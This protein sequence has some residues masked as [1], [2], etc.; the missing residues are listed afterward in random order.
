MTCFIKIG[1]HWKKRFGAIVLT[2]CS[3]SASGVAQAQSLSAIEHRLHRLEEAVRGVQG[4]H[5][6]SVRPTAAAS[7]ASVDALLQ[8]DSRLVALERALSVFVSAQEQD[9]RTLTASLAQVQALKGDFE[10]RLNAMEQQAAT[11]STISNVPPTAPVPSPELPPTADDRFRQAMSY[12]DAQ[13]WLKSELAFD[14]FVASWPS[15][16]RVPEARFQLGRAF[17]GQGKHAQAAQ[18]FLGLYETAP[19]APFALANLF[20]LAEVIAEIG[21]DQNAQACEVYAEIEAV[22]GGALTMEQRARLLDRRLDLK[23]AG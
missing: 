17:Q 1:S 9:H 20:A 13:D 21:P 10:S 19:Q 3:L 11:V 6:A 16:P 22:H 14:N 7:T 12:A 8:L 4:E 5:P 2:A 23:C 18:I 15:D